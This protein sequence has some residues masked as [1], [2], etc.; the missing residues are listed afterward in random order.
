VSVPANS[1]ID[2]VGAALKV[3]LGT[4]VAVGMAV[5]DNIM[6]GVVLGV[7]VFGSAV[8]EGVAV[9]VALDGPPVVWTGATGDGRAVVGEGMDVGDGPS[10]T[11]IW[12]DVDVIVAATGGTGG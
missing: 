6:V 10:A 9:L 5:A 1:G 3:A 12:F 11:G 8:A 7:L 4:V 2:K